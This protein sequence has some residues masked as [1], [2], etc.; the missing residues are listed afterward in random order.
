MMHEHPHPGELLK[1][2]VLDPLG[3]TVTEAAARLGMSRVSLSRVLNGKAGI[4][5][6]VAIR[7]ERAGI[8]SARFWM[9]LQSNYELE[10]ASRRK[11]PDVVPWRS[12]TQDMPDVR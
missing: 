11:Q 1:E 4:S 6:D 7:L 3:L 2:D 9:T 12:E 5:S 8:S 10:R